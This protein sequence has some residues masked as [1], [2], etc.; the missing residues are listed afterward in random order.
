[1]PAISAAARRITLN[2]PISKGEPMALEQFTDV[3]EVNP[4]P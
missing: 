2:V 3:I 4:R 1:L